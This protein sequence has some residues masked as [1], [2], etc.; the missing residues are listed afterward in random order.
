MF[1]L[2]LSKS[3]TKTLLA[4]PKKNARQIYT[5]LDNPANINPVPHDMKKLKEYEDILK[6]DVGEKI[7]KI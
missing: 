2:D 7:I 1:D 4:L 5:A 6:I 3:S